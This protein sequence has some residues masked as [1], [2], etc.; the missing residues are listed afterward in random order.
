MSTEQNHHVH[1]AADEGEQRVDRLYRA[2]IRLR[3][4]HDRMLWS[5]VSLLPMADRRK[6]QSVRIRNRKES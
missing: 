3:I 4:H 1:H 5:R 2:L 6:R